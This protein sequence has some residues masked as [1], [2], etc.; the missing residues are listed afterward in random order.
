MRTLGLALK[1]AIAG[2]PD[3]ARAW[4]RFGPGGIVLPGRE[5][6]RLCPLPVAALEV[7]AETVIALS[8]AGL[9]TLADLAARPS[10]TLSARFGEALVTKLRRIL[11]REDCRITPLRPPPDCVVERHFAEPFADVASLEAVVARLVGEAARVL[12]ARG[13]GGRAFE[14]AFF[15][16][17]GAVSR[18]ALET[19]RPSRDGK[20]LLRLYRERI[21][22][23][24]DPL[25]PGFGFDAIRLSVPLCEPL[26]LPQHSLDGRAVEEEAVADL[27]D[28]LVARFGRDR[29]L[30]F[31][32]QD[33][34]HP[35]RAA[36]ALSAA[37]PQPAT[38]WPEPEPDEPPARPLQLFEP[39]QPV[40]A[41][42]EVPD[43][44]PI[45]FR[46]RR[47]IHDVTRAEGP[48]RIAPEWWRDGSDEPLR[49]YYRVEDAEGRRFWL[50]RTGFHEAG[51]APPRWFLHGLFA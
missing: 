7:D 8:R 25:D 38:P 28:R 5:G 13:Q 45:R 48:E 15:R 18:L 22:T 12:E 46:W 19:G 10:E 1:A 40:E 21:E 36:K 34:H 32:A 16:S 11:G 43:G 26:S 29:V 47:L 50:Y 30:R 17:D 6:E 2:T 27:V 4:S 41:V 37:A 23:L 9:K 51:D 3:A 39:P 14:F 24:A 31:S 35:V 49:D 33:T 20:A 44:P 42:A